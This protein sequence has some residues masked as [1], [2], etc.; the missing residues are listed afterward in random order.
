MLPIPGFH[1]DVIH[2]D[3]QQSWPIELSEFV[4]EVSQE[5]VSDSGSFNV[6]INQ[7]MSRLLDGYEIYAHHASRL[8]S[9]EIDEITKNGLKP[10]SLELVNH[11]LDVLREMDG[12][13]AE[14]IDILI[15]NAMLELDPDKHRIGK[16]PLAI[17]ESDLNNNFC[18][19][20][21]FQKYW[22]GE[23]LYINMRDGV[24]L[25][26][27]L[28]F[29]IPCLIRLHVDAKALLDSGS[30]IAKVFLSSHV[31]E[32]FCNSAYLTDPSEISICEVLTPEDSKYRNFKGLLN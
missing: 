21:S 2:P 22:G 24:P 23:Y 25:K 31:G 6:E 10:L 17:G 28:K 12:F 15:E 20:R 1:E 30:D 7:E 14:E 9:L 13:T 4:L 32:E 11:K 29:G 27:K 26:E 3:Y 19:S 8:T 18:G 5:W 16:I